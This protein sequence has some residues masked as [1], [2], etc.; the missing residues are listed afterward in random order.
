MKHNLKF[1]ELLAKN[2]SFNIHDLNLQKLFIEVFKVIMKLALQIMNEVF[3]TLWNAHFLVDYFYWH[4]DV[5]L[6]T[7]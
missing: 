3:L 1:D 7:Q 2:G 4:E 6:H 5:E